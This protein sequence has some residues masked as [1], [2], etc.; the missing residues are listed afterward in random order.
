[1]IQTIATIVALVIG[2]AA[3]VFTLT[4]FYKIFLANRPKKEKAVKV[5]KKQAKQQAKEE[6]SRPDE[7]FKE[8]SEPE[9]K[10]FATE[11]RKVTGFELD[12]DD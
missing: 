7:S 3:L 6:A 1:M 4:I 11:N 8:E 12:D 5:S 10:L 9:I 2:L